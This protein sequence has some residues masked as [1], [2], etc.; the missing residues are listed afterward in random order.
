MKQVKSDKGFTL[1]ELIVVI[2]II[3]ILAMVALPRFA[4][5]TEDAHRASVDGIYGAFAVGVNLTHAQWVAGGK[6]PNTDNLIGFGDGNM[7]LGDDGWPVGSVGVD[8]SIN[9]TIPKCIEI[10]DALLIDQAP[11]VGTSVDMDYGVTIGSQLSQ[12]QYTYQGGGSTTRALVYDS[13]IG[14]VYKSNL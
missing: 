12:C 10:W 6:Q 4:D 1:I 5:L 14:A 9:M 13:A 3:A 7:N 2:S 11:T 8:N